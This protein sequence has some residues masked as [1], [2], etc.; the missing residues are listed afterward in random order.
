M[1]IRGTSTLQTDMLFLLI[2]VSYMLLASVSFDQK[3]EADIPISASEQ[4]ESERI[5]ILVWK[6]FS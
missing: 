4:D 2:A 6:V 1:K 5:K 3:N